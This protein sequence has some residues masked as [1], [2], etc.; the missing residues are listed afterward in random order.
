MNNVFLGKY[1]VLG[2]YF[3]PFNWMHHDDCS[4][5]SQGTFVAEGL[6]LLQSIRAREIGK[7]SKGSTRTKISQY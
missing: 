4:F 7:I 1:C 6:I 5:L 3:L 2:R